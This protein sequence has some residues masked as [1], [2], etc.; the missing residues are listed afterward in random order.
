MGE[1]THSAS[2]AYSVLEEIFN[3]AT[4]GLG[5]IFSVVALTLMVTLASVHA[6]AWA[7]VSSSIF[8]ASMFFMYSVSSFYHAI[9]NEKAKKILKKCDHI[10]IYYLIAGTYTPFMLV[11][12]RSPTGW[13]VFGI[14]WALAILGTFLKIFT[15]G[16]GTKIWSIA[17][18]MAMGWMII[19]V[20]KMLFSMLPLS[21]IVFL[22]LGG[23]FYTGGVFFYIQ[24]AKVYY[25]AIWHIFV[26]LGTIMHFFAVLFSCV[27][28][29]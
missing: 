7:I 14:I 21:G 28:H 6:D 17:L 11:S 9:P 19:F 4:H 29:I 24:K 10:A 26:L 12:M 8:G 2:K 22:V 5:V 27:I 15:S 1:K 25:H 13:T 20:S 23:L 3:S 16:S 18:Y